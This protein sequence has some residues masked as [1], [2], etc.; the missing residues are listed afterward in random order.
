MT[1]FPIP[2]ICAALALACPSQHKEMK[3]C[4]D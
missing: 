2:R 1:D 3:P 4:L